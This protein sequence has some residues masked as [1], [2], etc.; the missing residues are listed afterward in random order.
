MAE[1]AFCFGLFA[2]TD[3]EALRCLRQR[4]PDDHLRRRLL[5]QA[6]HVA[7]RFDV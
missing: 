2:T 5:R 3:A 1:R 6:E 7:M 4:L